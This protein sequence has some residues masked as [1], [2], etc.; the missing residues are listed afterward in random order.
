MGCGAGKRNDASEPARTEEK[1]EMKK[2]E[3]KE[4]SEGGQNKCILI[5]GAP[6]S[7]KG[8]QAEKIKEKYKFL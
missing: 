3:K 6:A 1:K 5:V 4:H 7:G 8:T 2:E